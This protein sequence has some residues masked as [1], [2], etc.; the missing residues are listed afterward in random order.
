M[1][2][3]HDVTLENDGIVTFADVSPF[4]NSTSVPI[5]ITL[6]TAGTADTLELKVSFPEAVEGDD[7]QEATDLSLTALVNLDFE[8]L[9]P[10]S[11]KSTDDM[12]TI[13]LL[14]NWN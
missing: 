7:I 3:D 4:E 5:K 12:E 8:K 13:A 2:S 1:L 10:V 11:Q 6:N 14:D 9:P